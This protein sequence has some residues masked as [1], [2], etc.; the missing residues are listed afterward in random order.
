[1]PRDGGH[2]HIVLFPRKIA[3][4]GANGRALRNG[5]LLR[6]LPAGADDPPDVFP[7][8]GGAH[9]FKVHIVAAAG[10]TGAYGVGI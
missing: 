8:S 10:E 1:M 3:V 4:P 7:P 6:R 9:G 2:E 5:P